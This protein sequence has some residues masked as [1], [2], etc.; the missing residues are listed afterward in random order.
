MINAKGEV[1]YTNADCGHE[2]EAIGN[3]HDNPELLS[4]GELRCVIL[5]APTAGR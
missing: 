5:S 3:I 4:G 1:I 2:C